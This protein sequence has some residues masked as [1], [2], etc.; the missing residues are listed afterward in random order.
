MVRSD[1]EDYLLHY[2]PLAI[3]FF[4]IRRLARRLW[5]HPATPTALEWRGI[6]LVYA[7]WP[8]YTLAWTMALL[9]APLRFR[10]TPKRASDPQRLWLVPQALFAVLLTAGVVYALVVGEDRQTLLIA[11]ALGQVLM[12]TVFFAFAGLPAR[13][14]LGG[15]AGE[16]PPAAE[17]APAAESAAPAAVRTLFREPRW[18]NPWPL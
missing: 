15:G 16:A 6:L 5:R 8:V 9:R 10:L 13:R 17:G 11:S 7:T 12:A 4:A 3:M 14:A 1:V 2:L 18:Q